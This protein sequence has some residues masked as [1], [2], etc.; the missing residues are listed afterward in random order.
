[1]NCFRKRRAVSGP[2]LGRDYNQMRLWL[3]NVQLGNRDAA[4]QALGKYL[5]ARIRALDGDWPATY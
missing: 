2:N 1:M 5:D 4:N 3:T